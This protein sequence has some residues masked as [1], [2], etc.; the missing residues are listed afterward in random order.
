MC[1]T[2]RLK[3]SLIGVSRAKIFEVFTV[4]CFRVYQDCRVKSEKFICFKPSS[5]D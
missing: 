1:V 5:V 3:H 4:D 2:D